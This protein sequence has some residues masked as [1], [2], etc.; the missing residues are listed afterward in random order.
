MWKSISQ[1]LA[2]QFGAYYNIKQKYQIFAGETHE[3]WLIDDGIQPVFVKINEKSYRSMF[4]AEADQLTLLAKSNTVRVPRVYGIGCSASHAFLLLEAFS[5]QDA[6][7]AQQAATLGKQLAQL[8]QWQ[9][10]DK[11]GLDFDT[12]LGKVHQPNEWK[13]NW[14]T[15]FSEQRIG[16]Q[17]QLCK[18]KGIVFGDVAHITQ[19]IASQLAK[20]NPTPALLHGDLWAKN[21]GAT[22][23]EIIV[24]D[25]ACYWGDRECD[26]AFS[27][28][29]SPF[30]T[31]FYEAYQH[32]YPLDEGYLQR[33]PIYQLYY[34][35]NFSHRYQGEYI[36][37][38]QQIIDLFI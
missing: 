17:L 22:A 30:P 18:E 4:R 13:T 16:W 28:L 10:Q 15:F 31:Q 23:Q 35:L 2:D 27:E 14:A 29:F 24:Y 34:L 33:K 9:A 7:N 3:A 5:F 25:P 6:P 32:A 37:K 38:A 20:H 26:L 11:Y 21:C 1:V 36:E 12:W 19:A 8:H